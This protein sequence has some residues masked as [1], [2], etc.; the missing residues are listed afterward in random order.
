MK[1][2]V[3]QNIKQPSTWKRGLYILLYS[4]CF[5]LSATLLFFIVFFQFMAKLITAETNDQLR[6]LSRSLAS[7]VYQLILFMS[8]NSN[9]KPYPY[10]DWPEG[11]LEIVETAKADISDVEEKL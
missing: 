2:N 1:H 3:E 4:I 10:G 11:E 9:D 8:F 7:Y 6:K 5:Q